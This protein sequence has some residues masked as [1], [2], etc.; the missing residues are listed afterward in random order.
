MT[1]SWSLTQDSDNSNSKI[2]ARGSGFIRSR[3]QDYQ[4][5]RLPERKVNPLQYSLSDD[6][7]TFSY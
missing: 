7:R 5:M 1:P 2:R 3:F 4:K 6:H